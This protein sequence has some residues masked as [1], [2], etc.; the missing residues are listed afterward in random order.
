VRWVAPI[1]AVAAVIGVITG[2]SLG[3]HPPGRQAPPG[4]PPYYVIVQ[5]GN[6]VTTVVVRDSLTGSVLTR[7]R[8]PF[9][10]GGVSWISGAADGRT[11][12]M[13][14]GND[15]FRLRLA[16]DGR[17]MRISRLPI[18]LTSSVGN[19]ALS[20]DGTTVE[21][22]SQ[23]CT[24][25]PDQCQYT[26]I[27]LVS[28]ATGATKTWTAA[29]PTQTG[30]WS[31]WDGNGHVLFS[32]APA[33]PTATRP[34]GYRLLD[35]TGRG[36]NLLS[37]RMLRLPPLPVV[38]G[39]SMPESAFITP[40]GRAVIASTL[41]AIGSGQSPAVDMKIAEWSLPSGRQLRVLLKGRER[42]TLPPAGEICWVFA[43]G[44]TG[45]HA[46]IECPYPKFVFGRWDDG[47]FTPLP[48]MTALS[49]P[50]PAAW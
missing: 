35:V 27:R 18:T 38:T 4:M 20:P 47:R 32:W 37:A 36:G 2:V 30:M 1:A 7:A 10:P 39:Y 31:S 24:G 48:G 14:N 33:H 8:V 17:S 44:P 5:D 22:E 49:G 29:A 19:V 13:N 40:D 3:T 43:L 23:T 25:T 9:L 42:P 11:F 41:T 50:A 16:A 45:T 34:S 21:L 12:V 6:P 28:L 15:L 26:T 46:L